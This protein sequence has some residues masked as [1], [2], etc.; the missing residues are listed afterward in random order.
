MFKHIRVYFVTILSEIAS[1]YFPSIRLPVGAISRS[2]AQEEHPYE[3]NA[4]RQLS[5]KDTKM[6]VARILTRL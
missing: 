5:E 4:A 2:N 3:T 1:V 6:K